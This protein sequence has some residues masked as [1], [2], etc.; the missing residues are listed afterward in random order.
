M[1]DMKR[2]LPPPDAAQAEDEKDPID[3]LNDGVRKVSLVGLVVF[4]GFFVVF[5]GWAAIAPLASSAFANGNVEIQGNRKTVQHK[6]GGVVK[7]LLVQEGSE[8]AAGDPL[9]VLDDTQ[10]AAVYAL[11]E[12]QYNAMLAQIARLEA[13]QVDAQE[14]TFPPKLVDA[15]QDNADI[16]RILA[17]QREAFRARRTLLLNQV[18]TL[19]QR[20]KQ[21]E[22]QIGGLDAQ[23]DSQN[24]QMSLL[25]D[26]LQGTKELQRKGHAPMTKVRAL[27]RSLASLQGQVGEYRGKIAQIQ[28]TK[29]E[30]ELQIIS[31]RHNRISEAS[32]KLAELRSQSFALSERLV[33]SKDILD[34]SIIRAPTRGRVLG[35][36]MHTEGGVVNP[37]QPLMD[38]VPEERNL[39][40]KAALEPDAVDNVHA[41]MQAEVQFTAFSS[42]FTERIMGK[43]IDISADAKENEKVGRLYYELTVVVPEEELAKLGEVEL[44]PGM[45]VTVKILTGDRTA[46]SYFLSPITKTFDKAFT[47][48]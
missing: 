38:I 48:Q 40:V 47:E 20:R 28:E 11:L 46:L 33:A 3:G 5:V 13:E 22:E 44:A 4:L 18:D 31:L 36:T 2:L 30:I 25:R 6:E 16:R 15:A 32:E 39:I 10:A 37:G 12:E 42:R 35:L 34:R 19:G 8:V 7:S 14:V 26:E 1:S 23:I 45:P 21:L 17:G 29:A 43:I 24:R 41:G 27:E 9:V